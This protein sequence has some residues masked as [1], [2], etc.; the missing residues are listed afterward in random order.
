[1]KKESEG[2]EQRDT[3]KFIKVLGQEVGGGVS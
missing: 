2:R 1:M 3:Q